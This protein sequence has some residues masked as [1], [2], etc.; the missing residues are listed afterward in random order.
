MKKGLYVFAIVPILLLSACQN[1]SK[2][3]VKLN[4]YD[5]PLDFHSDLQKEYLIYEDPSIIPS[6]LDGR[7]EYGKPEPIN[8]SWRDTSNQEYVFEYSES[9][10][11]N[12]YRSIKTKNKN[13][14]LLNLKLSTTYFYRI[15]TNNVYSDISSFETAS[16]GPRNLDIDGITNVRDCGGWTLNDGKVINQGLLFRGGRLNN[17]YPEGYDKTTD[18][19]YEFEAEITEEGKKEFRDNLGIKT[20][21]DFRILERNGYPGIKHE[22]VFPTVEGANYVQIPTDGSANIKVS[23][24]QI[25]EFFS[26][27]TDKNNYPMY[28][29]CN[30][31]TD[32]TGMMAYL[33]G[34]FLGMSQTD[35][36]HDYLFSD[37]GVIANPTPF[38]SNPKI[39]TLSSLTTGNG[40][41]AVVATYSGNNLQEKAKACLLDV[42]LSEAQ[43][44]AIKNILIK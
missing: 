40:A 35:L 11:F 23:K 14:N 10:N 25:K 8:I 42:G 15:K 43:L 27:L 22:E 44:E 1:A 13:V 19:G 36:Y 37:F 12:S 21:V 18:E 16:Y 3:T 41:A 31:G 4:S 33:L 20:E 7:H 28:F 9:E 6:Q 39:K 29:H 32:R 17:S 38:S 26:L 2:S 24:E 30:I 34:A 5:E